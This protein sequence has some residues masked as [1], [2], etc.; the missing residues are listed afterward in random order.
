MTPAAGP[1]PAA[2]PIDCGPAEDGWGRTAWPGSGGRGARLDQARGPARPVRGG[3]AA[4]APR[5]QA[6]A[7]AQARRRLQVPA[8]GASQARGPRGG[9]AAAPA[10]K[11]L[12]REATV[13]KPGKEKKKKANNARP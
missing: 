1:G 5:L 3:A 10:E 2:A 7:A 6:P 13:A 12:E 9:V 4:A 11:D 8:G